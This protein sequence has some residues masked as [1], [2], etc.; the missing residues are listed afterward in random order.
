MTGVSG[1]VML[2]SCGKPLPNGRG[3]ARSRERQR[4]VSREHRISR[5][6]DGVGRSRECLTLG[7][8]LRLQPFF[9]TAAEQEMHQPGCQFLWTDAI[10]LGYSRLAGMKLPREFDPDGFAIFGDPCSVDVGEHQDIVRVLYRNSQRVVRARQQDSLKRSSVRV[11][12]RHQ[13]TYR[14]RQR[15]PDQD[16]VLPGTSKVNSSYET[17]KG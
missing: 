2:C 10:G 16:F 4:A 9:V 13:E 11:C 7:E 14:R 5:S 12:N 1:R 6:D 3:S 17:P 8:S 15:L